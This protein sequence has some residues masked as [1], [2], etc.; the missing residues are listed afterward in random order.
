M[1]L[2]VHTKAC[3]QGDKL[4]RERKL[5]ALM[6]KVRIICSELGEDD[7]E[8]AAEAHPSLKHYR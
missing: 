2:R 4:K 1:L 8:V 6:G 7:S 5:D 3:P